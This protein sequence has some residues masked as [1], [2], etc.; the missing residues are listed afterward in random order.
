[1][2]VETGFLVDESDPDRMETSRRQLACVIRES[3]NNT[4]GRCKGVFYWEPECRPSQYK[5][6]AF[7]EDGRPTVIM[8]AFKEWEK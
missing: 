7:T 5:L 4:D 8:D 1:M 3:I 6:G 2:I